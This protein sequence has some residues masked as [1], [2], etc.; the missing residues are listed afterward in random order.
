MSIFF[1]TAAIATTVAAG[2]SI[3]GQQQAASA[4][5]DAADYNDQLAQAEARNHQL[6]TSE[7]I[8][9]QRETNRQQ[10][11]TLRNRLAS[12]G[13]SAST[14]TPLAILGEGAGNF[15]LAIQDAARQSAMEAAAIRAKGKMGLWD[16]K[17]TQAAA[18]IG[19]VGS[20][21]QAAAS[22]GK[23]YPTSM[24]RRTATTFP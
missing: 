13:V 21:A 4:A 7:A 22:I 2:A 5:S 8:K 10:L 9:R 6:E 3:Y 18:N 11:A 12:S 16:A 1:V 19:S 15:E 23:D 17:T 14:G 24:P 20:I